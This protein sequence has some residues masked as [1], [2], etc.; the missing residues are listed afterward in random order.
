MTDPS[1]EYRG[2]RRLSRAL[3]CGWCVAFVLVGCGFRLQMYGDGSIFSYGVAVEDAW[4]FH[5]RNI[6]GRLFSYLY[7]YLPAQAYVGWAND[8]RGGIALYGFL[9]YLAPALGLLLTFVADRS[10]RRTVFT[11]AC[12]STACLCP[13]VFGAPTE[14]WMTHAL[15]WPALA[16]SH[17]DGG[18]GRRTVLIF[19]LLT[20]L[21]LTHEGAIPLLGVLLLTLA[22]RGWQDAQLRRVSLVA[23]GALAVWLS[24]K[25]ALPPDAYTAHVL[26]AAALRLVDPLHFF[27]PVLLL[28]YAALAGYAVAS[29]VL[30][31]RRALVL[32]AAVLAV[33]WGWFDQSLHADDRYVVRTALLAG[34]ALL[35]LAASYVLLEGSGRLRLRFAPWERLASAV[36]PSALAGAIL[37][38]T[39]VHG[40]ETAKFVAAWVDYKAGMRELAMGEASDPDLGDPSFVSSQRLGARLNRMAWESTTHFLSVLVTPDL[41][42]RR[43]VVDPLAGYFWLSC[44]TARRSEMKASAVPVESRSLIRRHACLHR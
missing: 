42:P 1:A 38:V 12:L 31:P 22:L 44:D 26:R 39:L 40:V 30:T 36:S 27:R 37:L 32:V 16:L 5:W 9:D 23:A 13:L 34:T 3:G 14:L 21:A 15:F 18:K 7:A 4:A 28:L 20:A 41:A 35:G 33:Y 10:P 11:F 43:L 24:V 2:L 6:S 29:L 25:L 19:V 8:P 17:D